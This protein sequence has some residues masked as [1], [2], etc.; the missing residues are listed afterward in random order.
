MHLSYHMY[1][2]MC[3]DPKLW[4]GSAGPPSLPLPLPC[5][6]Q[7]AHCLAWKN[8]LKNDHR[9]RALIPPCCI[10]VSVIFCGC[11]WC[12]VTLCDQLENVNRKA[13]ISSHL[14]IMMVPIF[15]NEETEAQAEEAACPIPCL[16]P[17]KPML[18]IAGPSCLAGR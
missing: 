12:L 3:N 1:N 18:I 2:G 6:Q 5:P 14:L 8:P 15:Q 13:N 10:M 9:M 17:L 7:P 11:V 4:E 16:L